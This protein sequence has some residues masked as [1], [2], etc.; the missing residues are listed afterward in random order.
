MNP[1]PPDV[2]PTGQAGQS[3]SLGG[4]EQGGQSG[5]PGGGDGEREHSWISTMIDKIIP[6][7]PG[8]GNRNTSAGNTAP[9]DSQPSGT[10]NTD[11]MTDRSR[12]DPDIVIEHARG[13]RASVEERGN[14]IREER[15]ARGIAKK[16]TLNEHCDKYSRGIQPFIKF[17]LGGPTIPHDYPP[18]PTSE[19]LEALY[20]V[21]RRSTII[22]EQLE[23][24]RSSL[25]ARSTAEQDFF[26][27]QAEKEIRKNIPLPT[28]HPAP[29]KGV[30]SGGRPISTQT[31]ADVERA[32]AL[33]GI[34]RF[35][36]EW[37]VPRDEDSIWNSAVIE[38][39]GKKSV[40][41]LG[42]SIKINEEE[43][44]QAAAIIKRWLETKS[45]E[46]QQYGGMNKEEYTTLKSQKATKALLQRWR[47]KIKEQRCSMA[48][49]V[50]HDIPQLA[51]VLEDNY[52][53]S[54]IE[55]GSGGNNP[56]SLFPP[57]RSVS[58]T[59]I[60][61]NLNRMVQAQAT[62]HKTIETNKKMYARS[63]RNHAKTV[64]GAIGV[65]RDWPIDC[66]DQAFWK[67]LSK[68]EQDTLSKT[69][70]IK[71]SDIAEV[72]AGLC[73]KGSNTQPSGP[74]DTSAST[75][76]QKRLQPHEAA[77]SDA[78]P[79]RPMNVD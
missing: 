30:L 42:R 28:F 1:E 71:I 12:L 76:G 78:G 59:K 65:S 77:G 48:D 22:I 19:E 74:S 10:L 26:L 23:R 57:W 66:Y 37:N 44:G 50:F 16:A 15:R 61:H 64:G 46:I 67:G 4:G 58:L 18:S 7:L 72:L 49:K 9:M 41:W 21:D 25:S 36:F 73:R 56:V 3:T 11:G 24:L 35:T 68:F 79:S 29:R 55:E 53:H 14:R 47:K 52:C 69:P 5:T 62:H 75:R 54:D 31:K 6:N 8:A 40:E 39:M 20:W 51:V 2:E 38:V 60:L 43:A 13:A 45:R 63:A 32:L 33:A 17:F 34:S 27:A 70:A